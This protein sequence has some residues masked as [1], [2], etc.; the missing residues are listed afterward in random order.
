MRVDK[1]KDEWALLHSIPIVRIWEK[2]IRENPKGVMQMLR[3]R[4]YLEDDKGVKKI[5]KNKRHKNKLKK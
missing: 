4:L 2:D 3:D 1:L 5:E